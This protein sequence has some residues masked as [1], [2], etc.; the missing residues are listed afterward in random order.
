MKAV[1]KSNGNLVT[2]KAAELFVRI[3][4]AD[5]LNVKEPVHTNK[6]ESSEHVLP[7]QLKEV[8]KPVAKPKAKI[9]KRGRPNKK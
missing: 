8:A 6:V 2:G 3:G 1:F 5:E 7:E 9:K 4:I